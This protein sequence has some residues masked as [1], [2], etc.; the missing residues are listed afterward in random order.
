MVAAPPGG[1][2]LLAGSKTSH[3]STDSLNKKLQMHVHVS[4]ELKRIVVDKQK[5]LYYYLLWKKLHIHNVI[6]Y[7]IK[8]TNSYLGFYANVLIH[9]SCK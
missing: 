9:H 2:P 6:Y 8:I 7:D 3:F 1:L 4:I 5:I